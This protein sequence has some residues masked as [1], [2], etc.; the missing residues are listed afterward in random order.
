MKEELYI[1]GKDKI[2][3]VL[4][5]SFPN[6]RVLT[7]HGNFLYASSGYTLWR[8]DVSK[9]RFPVWVKVAYFKPDWIRRVGAMHRL[10]R[11][12]L[13][14]GFRFLDFLP[15]GSFIAVLTKAI[16][17]MKPGDLEFKLT[18]HVKRGTRPMGLAV[19]PQ[20]E[21]Y[22]GEYFNNKEPSE[23]YVYG[24]DDGGYTWDVIYTFPRGS[25]RHVHNVIYDNFENCFWILTGDEDSESSILKVSRDW[26]MIDTIFSGSQQARAVSLIL[27]SDEIYYATDTP[28]EQNYI[29]RIDRK[30]GKVERIAPIPGP[31][32]WSCWVKSAMFF[33]TAIEPSEVNTYPFACVHGSLDGL[34]WLKVIEWRKDWLHPSLFQFGNIVLPKGKNNTDLL[35]VTG[36]AVKRE[37]EV[38]KIWKVHYQN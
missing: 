33:S 35:A 37:D 15:D 31:S 11:R 30:S 23:V 24:S 13:R 29:Y 1:K 21:V 22:W 32:M 10:T 20:G 6:K 8:W 12:L 9:E 7:W 18:W 27:N 3:L 34:Q 14:V 17:V 2:K 26:R 25:I 4:I 5:A 16:A 36:I 38:T 19:T 28:Y